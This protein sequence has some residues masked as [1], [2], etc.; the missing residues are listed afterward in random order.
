MRL[1]IFALFMLGCFQIQAGILTKELSVKEIA[2]VKIASRATVSY[3]NQIFNLESFSAALRTKKVVLLNV[4]VYVAEIFK[5]PGITIDKASDKV[6]TSFLQHPAYAIQ[7]TFLRDVDAD[8]VMT[9]FKEALE[10]NKADL[11]SS[12]IKTL[13]ERVAQ[14][15]E[16][17][18]GQTLTFVM[19]KNS[20]KEPSLI[21]ENNKGE[22]VEISGTE[23][24][25]SILLMWFG[26]PADSGIQKLKEELLK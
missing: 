7:L 6:V 5:T 9:S 20:D 13:L 2:E 26:E 10:K 18:K 4:K 21:F 24:I 3:K 16:V 8:K 25:R 15:G 11:K 14:G 12:G 1:A 17:Q 22:I 23:N 19:Q